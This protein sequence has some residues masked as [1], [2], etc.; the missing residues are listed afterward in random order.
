M[1]R[2]L[3]FGATSAIVEP[4]LRIWAARDDALYLVARDENRLEA[5]AADLRVRGGSQV[6]SCFADLND[7]ARHND[8]FD[9]AE[10]L[11]GD[12]DIVLIAHGKLPDQKSCEASVSDTTSE[13]KTNAISTISL[14]TL[15]ANRFEAKQHGTISVISSV[16]GD[17]G[18]ASNYIYGSAKSM[19]NS[20]TSGLRQRLYKSGVTVVTIK[21]GFVDTPMT[22]EFEKSFLWVRPRTIAS[23]IV[24]AID[25]KNSE[26][27][28][29]AF[30][31][32]V[33]LIIT[34]IPE[35]VFKRMKL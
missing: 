6:Y 20:F 21:P 9:A 32:L 19:V 14:L 28:V 3:V 27:Y 12:V 1:K 7:M 22:A 30:W 4:C 26:V 17:R 15:A 8:L 16:A 31:R 34:G 25:K 13:I 33:M 35:V 11:M 2:I 29:P 23:S 18:R 5:I 24:L 10:E